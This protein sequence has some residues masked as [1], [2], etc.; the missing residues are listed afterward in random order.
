MT[1]N[2]PGRDF[3]QGTFC[4]DKCGTFLRSYQEHDRYLYTGSLVKMTLRQQENC[5][6]KRH[7]I[8][9]L[10]LFFLLL[11]SSQKHK[12]HKNTKI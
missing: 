10:L 2:I 6:S 12:C 5:S 1:E 8:H 3:S 7:Q 4:Y 11:I 9:V